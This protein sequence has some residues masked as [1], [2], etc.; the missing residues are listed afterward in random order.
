MRR[1]FTKSLGRLAV[2]VTLDIGAL[3]MGR[4]LLRNA[5]AG[6][7]GEAMARAGRD[8]FPDGAASGPELALAVFMG[9]WTLGAYRAGD[10]WREPVGILGGVGIGVVLSLYGDLWNGSAGL[11]VV[12]GAAIW[13]TFGLTLVLLRNLLYAVTQSIARP[14]LYH[15]VLVIHGART[16]PELPDLGPNFRIKADLDAGALPEDIEAMSDWLDGGIDTILVAGD[17]PAK[18][19]G[20]ITDFALAHGCRL[21]TMPRVGQLVG[22]DPQRIWIRGTPLFE[23]TGPTLRASQFFLKRAMDLVGAAVL[24][25]LLSP[26]M[27]MVAVAVRLDSPGPILFRH[28]R[29]GSRGRF[30]H[31]LKFRSMRADAEDLLGQDPELYRRY[32]E[33]D[34]KLPDREDPRVTSLGRFLRRS[35]LDELPQLFNVLR[36]EMS[37]VGPRPVVEPELE[38]YRGHIPTFLSVK[39]GVT[40][41]WQISGR[42]NIQFPERAELDLQYVRQWSLLEDIWILLMTVPAVLWRRGAH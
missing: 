20:K 42:S 18:G 17:L 28:R 41:L 30:F 24:V 21:F 19:F 5:R 3:S 13:L 33:N 2:L 4:E 39:P 37:L 40:G 15:R 12:R 38:M 29:A 31:L 22:V 26:V 36:G 16:D 10:R 32:V 7:F 1:H 8:F 23:I 35:S 27:L 34:F 9:L 6:G 14:V 11:V 25:V